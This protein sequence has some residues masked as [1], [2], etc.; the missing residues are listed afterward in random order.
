MTRDQHITAL[1]A[2]MQRARERMDELEAPFS[3]PA[4]CCPSCA[5]G[6][7]WN[8]L[9]DKR[10]R[11]AFWLAVLLL[12]GCAEDVAEAQ[13]LACDFRSVSNLVRRVKP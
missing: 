9:A 4:D 11:Q 7:E 3:F 13:A 12:K 5:C 6:P 2:A 8:A 1:R 10:E